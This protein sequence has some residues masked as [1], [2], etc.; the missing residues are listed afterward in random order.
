MS[1]DQLCTLL[2]SFADENDPQNLLT[3]AHTFSS[4]DPRHYPQKRRIVHTTRGGEEIAMSRS[5]RAPGGHLGSDMVDRQRSDRVRSK[6]QSS[7]V[8]TISTYRGDGSGSYEKTTVQE[9]TVAYDG[10]RTPKGT[11][12]TFFRGGPVTVEYRSKPNETTFPVESSKSREYTEKRREEKLF[13]EYKSTH[14][15][16]SRMREYLDEYE[17]RLARGR[18]RGGRRYDESGYAGEDSES[19]HSPIGTPPAS[20]M[21]ESRATTRLVSESDSLLGDTTATSIRRTAESSRYEMRRR[22]YSEKRTPK[23]PTSP[24][25]EYSVIKSTIPPTPKTPLQPSQGRNVS[26][27]RKQF[28]ANGIISKGY[29]RRAERRGASADTQR[30]PIPVEHTRTTERK[31]VAKE[32]RTRTVTDIDAGY[33]SPPRGYDYGPVRSEITETRIYD[34]TKRGVR[35][36]EE[37][38][39]EA[40]LSKTIVPLPPTTPISPPP[41]YQ[42]IRPRTTVF[43]EITTREMRETIT[44]PARITVAR[45][46]S[47]T[48]VDETKRGRATTEYRRL[49][50]SSRTIEP[51]P[52]SPPA[53]Q[54]QKSPTQYKI[55]KVRQTISPE[56]P[57]ASS[58]AVVDFSVTRSEQERRQ[59][60]AEL[61]ESF[62]SKFEESRT[63]TETLLRE[64]ERDRLLAEEGVVASYGRLSDLRRAHQQYEVEGFEVEETRQLPPSVLPSSEK[65]E[66]TEEVRETSRAKEV[67]REIPKEDILK[68]L[69]IPLP[70]P[71]AKEEEAEEVL[72][73]DSERSSHTEISS[74]YEISETVESSVYKRKAPEP[75]PALKEEEPERN[76]EQETVVE[77]LPPPL[78]AKQ[79][80]DDLSKAESEEETRKAEEHR[81][82][83]V[84]KT[85]TEYEI[86]T[87]VERDVKVTRKSTPSA[88]SELLPEPVKVESKDIG[89]EAHIGLETESVGI[90]A[91]VRT[92]DSA[93]TAEATTTTEGIQT[94]KLSKPTEDERSTFEEVTETRTKKWEFEERSDISK[95]SDMQQQHQRP[96]PHPKAQP[97]LAP[98]REFTSDSS[99]KTEIKTTI[100]SGV[101]PRME[102]ADYRSTISSRPAFARHSP[103][104][105]GA[106]YGTTNRVVKVVTEVGSSSISGSLS[107]FSQNAAMSIRDAR[108]R[109]KKEMS[110]LNDRLAS[111]IEKVRFLEAQN[112]KLAADLDG[113]RNRWGK[114]TTSVRT[115][116]ESE[117]TE[118]RRLIE[119]TNKQRDDMEGQIKKLQAELS[120]YRRKYEEAVRARE[121]DKERI[122]ELLVKLSALE[123]E[124]SLLKRRIANLEDDVSRAKKENHRMI[125]ELQRATTDLD[126]ET[127]NR[128]D[129]QNQVQTLMEEID[130]IRRVH[131]QEISELQAIASRD[132]TP[133]NREF[134][135]NEL[136]SAIRDIRAEYDRISSV[137]RTDM[138]SWYKL[139]VQ[140]IQTQSARQNM[141]QTYAKE[142]VKRLRVQLGDLRGKLADLEGRNSLLEKQVEELNYQLEDDQ[143]SY[144]AA[145]N[146]RDSGIR[147]M[148]EECKSLMVELQM[149]LDTK[150]TLDAEIAIY[151]KML[152]GEENRAGLRQLVEQVVRTH[153]ISQTQ[154]SESLRVLKGET[155]SRTSFQRSAKGNVSIHETSPDGKFIIIENTH[156]SREENIGEWKL[157]RKIDGKREL[158]FTFPKD[159]ILRPGKSVKIWARNQGIN[160]PP[161]QLVFDGEDS[162]GTGHNVQTI[163]YNI[164]GE[165]RAT[166]IQRSSHTAQ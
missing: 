24:P 50:E 57:V 72:R 159:F 105:S 7:L 14:A 22:S 53:L 5:A 2:I 112:R 68:A 88:P 157:K 63:M 142:E 49:I 11:S 119:E 37:R 145:L 107:P 21:P 138:E 94:E 99:V 131:D 95:T 77:D 6:S 90:D 135:K 151:R 146:D 141:E 30:T 13:E 98:T 73:P 36:I 143:R 89:V 161:D 10:A 86:E 109:E 59:R 87:T 34:S 69:P 1:S 35:S 152:E 114:D 163:L 81:R 122:D 3:T 45:P 74:R 31:P 44:T 33:Y 85:T 93:S 101:T 164:Q 62:R 60:E 23:L 165:E 58:Q 154:E 144:E 103:V 100:G 117:L 160:S 123:S 156:R 32:E 153:G 20:S 162:F 48:K 66:L 80:T 26:E 108:E 43:K 51:P 12:S 67:T 18:A 70:Q 75:V 133:E 42:D 110:D 61:H 139:K 104:S 118:A 17:S 52:L 39:E 28:E 92:V 120:E 136:A 25:P 8:E 91:T 106:S 121:E 38:S 158:V 65:I 82:R 97:K 113:L 46:P 111:Y 47:P 102:Q 15:E 27:I 83:L 134:F 64:Q 137:N 54:Q 147:K 29:F 96:P 166:H 148:R 129:F 126:H 16:R 130:F 155:S 4:T 115:M 84:E 116:Y 132:T 9:I 150:Q 125:G 56:P 19:E 40:L 55:E 128:I 41:A 149:L 140:E 78:P 127:L 79:L 124:I 76:R 71:A